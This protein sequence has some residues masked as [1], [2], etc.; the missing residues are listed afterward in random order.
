VVGTF[1]VGCG[2]LV[3]GCAGVRSEAPEEKQGRTEAT[4]GQAHSGGAASEEGRCGRMRTFK[5][6]GAVAGWIYRGTYTTNDVP[7]CPN[8]GLISGTDKRDELAGEDGEDM[9]RGLGDRDELLGGSGSD[10]LYGGPGADLLYGEEGDDVLYGGDGSDDNRVLAGGKGEDVVYGGDGND[11]IYTA[12]DRQ[13]DKLYCGEGID[14]Y[15]ADKI[16]YVSSSCEKKMRERVI[17]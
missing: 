16:D 2:V 14:W 4:T 1:L 8:G 15:L 5:D 7:G 9:V 13:R 11:L 6:E 17:S 12:H 10:V 3:A